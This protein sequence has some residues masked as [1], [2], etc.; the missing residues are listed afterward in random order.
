MNLEQN[1]LLK[2]MEEC[3]EI[4]QICSKAIRFGLLHNNEETGSNFE[5]LNNEINDLE[6]AYRN[7]EEVT[8]LKFSGLSG[9]EYLR[10][11]DRIICY[12]NYSK[13]LG[14]LKDE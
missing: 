5:K 4:Q 10:R 6:T 9:T 12:N 1:A 2:I 11:K 13:E 3:S 14:R 7:F 8:K